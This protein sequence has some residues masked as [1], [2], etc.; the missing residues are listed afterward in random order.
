MPADYRTWFIRGLS[1]NTNGL[2]ELKITFIIEAQSAN[3]KYSFSKTILPN[4]RNRPSL[5]NELPQ[6]CYSRMTNIQ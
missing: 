6:R 5:H 2:G 4:N 3:N 1:I